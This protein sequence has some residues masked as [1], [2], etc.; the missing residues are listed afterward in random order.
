MTFPNSTEHAPLKILVAIASYGVSNNRYLRQLLAEYRSMPF[1]VDIVVLS[2]IDKADLG[3]DI[4]CKV[5]LPNKDPW[6]LPFA[7]KP[8][9]AERSSQYDLF[10]YSEDD[11]LIT[12]SHIRAFL[13][14]N[15]ILPHTEIPGFLRI[16]KDSND[17]CSYPDALAYFHWDP[18]SIRKRNNVTFAHFTNEHAACY[19]LTRDQLERAISSGGFLTQP[20][21]WKYDLLCTAATDPYTKCGMTKLIPISAI[22][23]F[24]VHHLSNKYIGK[25]GVSSKEMNLQLQTMIGMA[26][27][28]VSVASLLKTETRLPR[29]L[30]S[31]G[32]YDPLDSRIIDAIPTNA[33][34]ILSVGCGWGATERALAAHGF[35]VVAAPLD[36]IIGSGIAADGIEIVDGDIDEVIRKLQGRRFD[37]VLCLNI[38]HLAEEPSVL[39]TK[40]SG[41]LAPGSTILIQSPN[42]FSVRAFREALRHS[43][44]LPF[45]KPYSS[46]G[47]RFSSVGAVKSWCQRSG[48]IVKRTD[49]IFEDP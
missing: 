15:Q 17:N 16:E 11:I 39:L 14:A 28:R 6:S 32:Y 34:T 8:L 41:S 49:S 24:L 33:R 40:I 36:P 10:I 21:E 27:S 42:M 7:H 13:R 30:Y 12:E 44:N 22:D 31:K 43:A 2:N 19:I 29:A 3:P 20:Y 4:E 5:G 45:G 46:T 26:E 9:F 23:D 47:L 35:S 25:D 38:L 18:A 37:C 1:Q 48:L